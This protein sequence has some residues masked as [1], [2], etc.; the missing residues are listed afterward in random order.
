MD[1]MADTS[2]VDSDTFVMPKRFNIYTSYGSNTLNKV[3]PETFQVNP[4]TYA[5]LLTL[6]EQLWFTPE[7][8][9]IV[10]AHHFSPEHG[11]TSFSIKLGDSS[12]RPTPSLRV[13]VGSDGISRMFSKLTNFDRKLIADLPTIMHKRFNNY[14][15]TLANGWG[16][17]HYLDYVTSY[18][19]SW[20]ETTILALDELV[21]QG[22]NMNKIWRMLDYDVPLENM[23][24][25][26]SLP[27]SWLEKAYSERT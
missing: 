14:E 16:F 10:F 24:D 22:V 4:N 13:A 21:S 20:S 26:A 12:R 15:L 27:N 25:N 5:T 8:N 1:K 9:K 6:E 17:M 3:D 23:L 11:R 18:M 7:E 19:F 2:L